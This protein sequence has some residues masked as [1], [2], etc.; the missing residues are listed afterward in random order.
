MISGAVIGLEQ[1]LINVPEDID[2]V[3]LCVNVSFPAIDCPITFPFNIRLVTYDGT[4][5]II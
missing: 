5:G 4:A 3:E 1:T 2:V